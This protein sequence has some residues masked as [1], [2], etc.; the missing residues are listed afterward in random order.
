MDSN[1]Y[2]SVAVYKPVIYFLTVYVECIEDMYV[3][4]DVTK[5]N[6]N[7]MMSISVPTIWSVRQIKPNFRQIKIILALNCC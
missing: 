7:V 1:L 2:L 4:I 3:I 6:V 5:E